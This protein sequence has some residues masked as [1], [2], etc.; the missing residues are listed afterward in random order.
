MSTQSLVEKKIKAYQSIFPGLIICILIGLLAKY[1]GDYVPTIGGATL[2]ILIGIFLG[3]TLFTQSRWHAGVR[4]S[5]SNLLNYSIVLLGGTLSYEVILDLGVAG[6]SFIIIQMILT[7]TFVIYL[8]KKL[9][10]SENFS[11]LMAAGN[12]VCGSS[13]IG[14]TSPVI[15]AS[16]T[17]KSITITLVNLTGTVLMIML[18]FMTSI[19]YHHA[20]LPTSALMGGT[21]QSVGQVIGSASMV[22]ESV[23][24][25]ATIFKIVRIIFLV[26][27][28]LYFTKLKKDEQAHEGKKSRIS[29]PW[30]VTGFFIMCILFSIGLISPKISIAFKGIS[31]YLEIF[32]L[33]GIGMSVKFKDLMSQGVKSG[34]YCLSIASSQL[35][36]AIIL[37]WIL[38]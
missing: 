4:F 25:M 34:I 11:L 21:L 18:P 14:A 28:I 9:G 29:I 26:F 24:E 30:Y 37:I 20:T 10:F 13:A 36:F 3:N 31:Q 19:L 35:I 5:E 38:F 27:V 12:S 22:N 7:I 15:K 2:A 1:L 16:E 6:V 33:A 32:A 8:G 23:K 17:D